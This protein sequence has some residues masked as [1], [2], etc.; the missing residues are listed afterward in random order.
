MEPAIL[1]ADE[2]TGNLDSRSGEELMLLFQD[3]NREGV[4]IILVT[5][6]PQVSRHGTRIV[7]MRDGRIVADDAVSD[8]LDAHE[9]IAAMPAREQDEEEEEAT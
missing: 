4:T 5:H 2:P 8:R 1:L 9:L 6:D 7:R 3:L